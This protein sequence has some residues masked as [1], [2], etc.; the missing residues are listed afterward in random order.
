MAPDVQRNI[1][2]ASIRDVRFWIFWMRLLTPNFGVGGIHM[3]SL[4][5]VQ[6]L[7]MLSHIALYTM[8]LRQF[9]HCV[10][11]WSDK[12]SSKSFPAKI[13]PKLST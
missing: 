11:L 13:K 12:T 4:K 8:L 7:N 1:N 6:G 9:Q 3:H 2:G 5:I 10:V